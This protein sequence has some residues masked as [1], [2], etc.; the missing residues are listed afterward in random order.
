MIYII[1]LVFPSSIVC[2][3]EV[4]VNR[5]TIK[6]KKAGRGSAVGAVSIVL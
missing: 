4:R 2:T 5:T 6:G 1:P 3:Q